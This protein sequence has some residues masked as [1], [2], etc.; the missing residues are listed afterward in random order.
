MKRRSINHSLKILTVLFFIGTLLSNSSASA[1]RVGNG[2]D[3]IRASFIQMGQAVIEYLEETQEGAQIV[4][5]NQLDLKVLNETLDIERISVSDDTLRD[6]S[7]SIVDALGEPDSITLQK[8]SW[9][10]HLERS[11][12]I[13]FLVFHEMLRSAGINDDNYIISKSLTP[14]PIARKVIT[15]VTPVLPLIE[16]DNLSSIFDLSQLSVNG[17]GCPLQLA[18]TQSSF[19]SET[20]VLEILTRQYRNETLGS[21]VLQRRSCNLAIPIKLPAKKRLSISQIDIRGKVDIQ[22]KSQTQI[23]FEAFLAGQTNSAKTKTVSAKGSSSLN[24]R[25]QMRR[26]E[27]M[28]SKCG[29]SDILRLNSALLSDHRGSGSA[30]AKPENS[31]VQSIHIFLNLEDCP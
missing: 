2:G 16:E 10:N 1:H 9:F 21:R 6:N 20:N 26:T 13:Y 8:T 15:K 27:L 11:T 30:T 7:G 19:N 17:S 14:F 3:H 29:G 28:K 4:S 5:Q 18:G 25:F 22:S 31:E 23:S 12:D 24:G